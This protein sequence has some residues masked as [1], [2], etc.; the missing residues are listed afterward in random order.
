MNYILYFLVEFGLAW[1]IAR[2]TLTYGARVRIIGV[3]F[4]GE[5][6]NCVVCT[7]FWISVVASLLGYA[8]RTG[9]VPNHYVEALCLG[10]ATATVNLIVGAFT[11]T[12]GPDIVHGG[13]DPRGVPK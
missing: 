6:F 9:L 11:G 5:L 13:P 12:L 3:P 2:S 7:G 10:L 8:P 1:G 4:F